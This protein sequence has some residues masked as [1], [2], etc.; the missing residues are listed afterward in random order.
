MHKLRRPDGVASGA[1]VRTGI[2][3]GMALVG[4]VGSTERVSYT[5]IGDVVNVAS[6]RE[7]LGKEFGTELAFAQHS[8]SSAC[9]VLV[10]EMKREPSPSQVASSCSYSIPSGMSSL[11]RPSL[12]LEFVCPATSGISGF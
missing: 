5:A 2:N 8:A 1:A 4:H 7:A 11:F 3:T 6:R 9:D 10:V 12:F